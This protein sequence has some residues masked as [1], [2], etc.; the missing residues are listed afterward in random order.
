MEQEKRKYIILLI[1]HSTNT[2]LTQGRLYF[3]N[4]QLNIVNYFVRDIMKILGKN[5]TLYIPLSHY[6]FLLLFTLEFT[7]YLLILQTG[8]VEYHHS[9]MTEIWMIPV[10]GIIGI[11][12]SI[13]LYKYASWLMP[14]ALF[15]Q[16]LLSIDYAQANGAELFILGYISGLT[17]PILIYNI[18][19][20]WI[21]V[22][23]LSFSYA[24]GTLLFHIDAIMRTDIALTLTLVALF[25]T[26]FIHF[27]K[28]KLTIATDLTLYSMGSIFLWLLLDASLFETLSRDSYMSLWGDSHY[29]FTIILSHSLGLALAYRLRE[30]K[31]T[32]ATL[33]ILFVVSYFLYDT[34][35]KTLLSIVY[36]IVISYYNVIILYKLMKLNYVMLAVMS[37]SLWGASGLGLFIALSG[38]FILAWVVLFFLV[39][40]ILLH[41]KKYEPLVKN[42]NQVLHLY[43]KEIL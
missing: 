6:S 2:P 13:W 17:A 20:L 15:I 3:V 10:G 39:I 11:I 21:A 31:Y 37:L 29:T 23:G 36:P 28:T 4:I 9:N 18:K 16:L 1:S 41:N 38:H 8:I 14:L 22:I 5:K 27:E 32:D 34:Q 42:L 7:Y 19:Y 33:L 25:S 26:L 30:W 43:K 12:S 24:L 35:E 40:L